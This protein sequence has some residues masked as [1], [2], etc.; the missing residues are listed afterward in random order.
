MR[1]KILTALKTPPIKNRSK[2]NPVGEVNLEK[3]AD[4]LLALSPNED[5]IRK[6]EREKAYDRGWNNAKK[7]KERHRT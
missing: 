6:D 5:E 2:K 7:Y 3:L 1:G 4:Y